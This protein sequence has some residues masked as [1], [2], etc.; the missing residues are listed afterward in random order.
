MATLNTDIKDVPRVI[1]SGLTTAASPGAA[2]K[3]V[4]QAALAGCAQFT[5]TFGGATVI[6]QG[7][8][9]GTNWFTLKDLTGTNVSAT[10]A[11]AFEFTTSA[12]YIRASASGGTGDSI[13]VVVA[14]RG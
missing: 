11:G 9:D 10:A 12:V 8:N 5:G 1:W 4:S 14:L 3:I 2:F 6:M 7:S 13:D